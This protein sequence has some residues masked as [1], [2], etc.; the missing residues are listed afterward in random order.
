[1][2]SEPVDSG[3]TIEFVRALD[4][5]IS[6]L[7]EGRA[8]QILVAQRGRIQL[9]AGPGAGSLTHGGSAPAADRFFPRPD[10]VTHTPP[11]EINVT[12]CMRKARAAG[13]SLA[14]RERHYWQNWGKNHAYVC[15]RMLFP[16]SVDEVGAAVRMAEND[17]RPLRAVGGGWSFSDV[18]LPGFVATSR[19]GA[20]GLDALRKLVQELETFSDDPRDPVIAGIPDP[21]TEAPADAAD[22][23]VMFNP[24]L[25]AADP[26]WRYSGM[27]DWEITD[28]GKN[29]IAA[30]SP[31]LRTYRFTRMPHFAAFT[32]A[33]WVDL[34]YL[35]G[36]RPM[37]AGT[38]D[39]A[40]TLR[41]LDFATSLVVSSLQYDGGGLWT[42]NPAGTNSA[43]TDWSDL[44]DA[45]A[46]SMRPVVGSPALDLQSLAPAYSVYVVNTQSLLSSLQQNLPQLLSADA[47]RATTG[48]APEKYYFHVEAGITMSALSELLQHQSPRLAIEATGGSPGATLAGA[49]ATATHGGE[50]NRPLLVDRVKAVHL[51]GPGGLQW[52]IE[53]REPVADPEKLLAAYP[54]LSRDRIIQGTTPVGGILPQDWLNA[55]VVSFGSVGIIYSL[56]L[57]VV[58]LF[59]IHEVVVQTTWRALLQRAIQPSGRGSGLDDLRHPPADAPH[60]NSFG[61]TLFNLLLD[62]R[63]NGTGIRASD[64]HYIDL[65][66]DPNRIAP[67]LDVA[68][69]EPDWN[70]W[71]LNR[72]M[73]PSV[74]FE[75]KPPAKDLIGRVVASLE[76]TLKSPQIQQRLETALGVEFLAQRDALEAIR[77]ASYQVPAALRRAG[78]ML[79]SSDLIDTI[80]D[81]VVRRVERVGY[82]D[83]A[84]AIVSGFFAGLLGVEGTRGEVTGSASSVGDIGFP[85]GGIMG[86]AIEIAMAPADAFPFLQTEIL[87]R[88]HEPFFGYVSVRICPRTQAL[89][90][91]QQ[92]DVS[93]MIEVVAFGTDQARQ[94]I[95][96]LQ[97]RTVEKMRAGLNAMLH[98]GLENDRLDAA[99][100]RSI[101]ALNQGS[102]SK[103]EK[104]RAVR[105]LIK[106]AAPDTPSVFDNHTTHRLDL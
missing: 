42:V 21:P 25:G 54:C 106:A 16:R 73:T 104:F 18:S 38:S 70:C 88:I 27:G 6:L 78:L 19:P 4:R 77:R 22:S 76:Q 15:E 11:P 51:V 31:V 61:G 9:N 30:Q 39:G 85:S 92:F 5:Q 20:E 43:T 12:P 50:C 62:G 81:F 37:A 60:R 34:A 100:L 44:I 72:E 26:E 45:L 86:T 35:I 93:V 53:G 69:S 97:Q 24:R 89:L 41:I 64:N 74:P 3:L 49:L 48:D 52:W 7:P 96:D 1:M 29:D 33:E 90:G 105:R 58:P 56:V 87:D 32:N 14:G 84:R 80:L 63:K 91:M 71:V 55:V 67:R 36:Y 65:A 40:G 23:L 82:V 28:A 2:K 66:I 103:L 46:P 83:V 102:P 68:F 17:N 10:P 79:R 101:P 94:F 59:G 47:A 95:A 8:R 57:E 98:W 13:L 99:T 75:T